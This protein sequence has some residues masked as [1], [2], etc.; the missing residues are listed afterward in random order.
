MFTICRKLVHKLIIIVLCASAST[1]VFA[2]RVGLG[3]GRTAQY[4]GSSDYRAI[5]LASF[6][7][8]TRIGI[9]SSEQIGV[10]IDLVKSR[11]ID[12]GPIL[13]YQTGRDNSMS[14]NAVAS[15]TEVSGSPEAGWFLGSG[16][17]LRVLGLNSDSILTG[18]I[19]GVTDIG[20]GHGGTSLTT[21]TAL[22]IPVNQDL[23]IITSLAFNFSNEQYQQSFF[24]VSEADALASGLP[25]FNAKGGLEST[26]I[27]LVIAKTINQ[28]W[29]VT[30]ITSLSK[31]QNDAAKSPLT[32]R[33]SASQLFMAAVLSYQ[34]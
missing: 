6:S 33:G 7:F 14:D 24:G 18:K 15:L 4:T 30:S 3:I 19:S 9:V 27:G 11:K 23:R 1:N 13:K 26:S 12:T 16:I 20:D 34:F 5:P 2:N 29:S 25:A 31:L 32:Q 10:K 17:P 22:V 8:D 28:R 21:S